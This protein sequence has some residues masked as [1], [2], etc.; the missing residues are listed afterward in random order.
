MR[1]PIQTLRPVMYQA[2]E[3]VLADTEAVEQLANLA[4]VL[5]VIDKGWLE[6]VNPV[7]HV[8]AK[9]LAA[10]GLTFVVH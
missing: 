8:T 6:F 3:D 2:H 5:S 4:E 10:L 9:G 1:T 7:L